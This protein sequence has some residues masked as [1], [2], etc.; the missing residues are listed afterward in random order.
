MESTFF[1][2]ELRNILD[3]PKPKLLVGAIPETTAAR[4]AT[5]VLG[6]VVVTPP[7]DGKMDYFDAEHQPRPRHRA[8]R[9]ASQN[10]LSGPPPTRRARGPGDPCC[11]KH[12]WHR[13]SLARSPA[14][15]GG[16]AR[17]GGLPGAYAKGERPATCPARPAPHQHRCQH[18]HGKQPPL[19]CELSVGRLVEVGG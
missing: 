17:P 1:R 7:P 19:A 6:T 14:P 2:H 10:G 18:Q 13:W 4:H 9:R 8:N 5:R 11:E 3:Q 15:P 16:L 12:R